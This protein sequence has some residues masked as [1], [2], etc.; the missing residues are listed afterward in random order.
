MA[1]LTTLARPYAKAAFEYARDHDS[2]TQWSEQLGTIA[3]VSMEPRIQARLTDP[4][5]AA[6]EQV[7]LLAG[8]CGDTLDTATRNF[9]AILADNK[10]LALLPQVHHLFVQFKANFEKSVEVEVVSA[11]DLE[12]D[13]TSKLS[14]ALG[15]KLERQVNVRT[16]TDSSL[17]GGVLIRAGDLVIDGSVRGRLKKLAAAMNS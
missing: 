12:Q 16:T 3:A 7:E 6:Q 14:A 13:M 2:L 9:L 4:A 17:L 1:E 8:V 11:F 10:R 15:R 5:R